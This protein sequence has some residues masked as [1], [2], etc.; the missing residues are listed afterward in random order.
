M[1]R[2]LLE[3]ILALVIVLG[4]L[5]TA[6]LATGGGAETGETVV[7]M[8]YVPSGV[9]KND[10]GSY[11]NINSTIQYKITSEADGNQT[12]TFWSD[13]GN[14]AFPSF[15]IETQAL[16]ADGKTVQTNDAKYYTPADNVAEDEKSTYP[17]GYVT[18]TNKVKHGLDKDYIP[19]LWCTGDVYHY[20]KLPWYSFKDITKVVFKDSITS[21]GQFTVCHLPKLEKVVI[22]NKDCNIGGNA[23][24]FNPGQQTSSLLTVT[25]PIGTTLATNAVYGAT[26][27]KYSFKEVEEFESDKQSFFTADATPSK[28]AVQ[29]VLNIVAAWASAARAQLEGDLIPGSEQSYIARLNEYAKA[30]GLSEMDSSEIVTGECPATTGIHYELCSYDGGKTY[31]LRFYADDSSDGKMTDYK[32]GERIVAIP[33]PGFARMWADEGIGPYGCRGRLGERADR[34]KRNSPAK[35]RRVSLTEEGERI[36]PW[37]RSR[38]LPEARHQSCSSRHRRPE[39]TRRKRCLPAHPNGLRRCGGGYGRWP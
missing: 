39:T 17:N 15:K 37:I 38:R 14:A 19:Y 32:V 10:D 26:S 27:V 29:N 7:K 34:G 36:I 9:K 25:L 8:G 4:L 22:E 20:S 16:T 30:H 35:H 11:E 28:D 5:P 6:A 2:R 31:A 18:D 24:F 33:T 12:L 21:I 23:I 3:S 13:A 1:K